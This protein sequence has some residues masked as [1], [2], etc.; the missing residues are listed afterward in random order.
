MCGI[1]RGRRKYVRPRTLAEAR[2]ENMYSLER[3]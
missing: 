1:V 3:R 2:T